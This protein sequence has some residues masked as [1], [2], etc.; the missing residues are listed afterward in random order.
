MKENINFTCFAVAI[1]SSYYLFF[2]A[3]SDELD[4]DGFEDIQ[5]DYFF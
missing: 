2:S 4:I 5:I 3:G 1:F